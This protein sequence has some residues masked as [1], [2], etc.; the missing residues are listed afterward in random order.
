[1]KRKLQKLGSS[2]LAVSLPADWTREQDLQKGD[3]LVI[4]RDENGGSLLVIPDSPQTENTVVTIDVQS[5]DVES[6]R[7]AILAQYVLGRRLIKLENDGPLDPAIF[8]ALETVERQLMGLGVVEQGTDSIAIRCS[9]APGDFELP[10]LMERLWRTEATMRSEAIEALLDGDKESAARAR[11]QNHQVDKLFYLFLRLVFATYRNPR[12]NQSV[13][14]E[15]GFPLIGYRSVAQ[16]VVLMAGATCRIAQLVTD[17][18]CP[19]I[20]AET[21]ES[22]SNVTHTLDDLTAAVREAVTE[23]ASETGNGART[24][25]ER[26]KTAIDQAQDHLETTRPEPLLTLQQALTALQQSGIHAEDSLD[27]ATHFAYRSASNV[28]SDGR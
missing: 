11:E 8:N 2:T 6:I 15:T 16:D 20:D 3:E 19:A 10:T 17:A 22:F 12:L 7:R 23:P 13:G 26:F 14:L 1:M 28:A 5:L 24:A 21:A 27:V 4:Q 9:V 18:D 25:L